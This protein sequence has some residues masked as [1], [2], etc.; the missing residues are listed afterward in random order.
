MRSLTA[1]RLKIISPTRIATDKPALTQTRRIFF[2]CFIM[3][4]LSH[5]QPR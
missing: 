3:V 1:K 5:P 4:R 2:V